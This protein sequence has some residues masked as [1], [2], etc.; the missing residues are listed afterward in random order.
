MILHY[1]KKKENKE[2]I[3]ATDQYKK[4]LYESSSFLNDNNFFLSP[5]IIALATIIS[6]YK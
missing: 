6:E 4:I 1:F 3:I 2:K 5:L